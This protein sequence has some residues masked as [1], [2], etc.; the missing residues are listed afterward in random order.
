MPD[1]TQNKTRGVADH[2]S[3]VALQGNKTPSCGE[4]FDLP[5]TIPLHTIAPIFLGPEKSLVRSVKNGF[6]TI[7][8]DSFDNSKRYRNL[9]LSLLKMK[10][11]RRNG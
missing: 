1:Y 3:G 10:G 5:L 4:K 8:S 9:D 7:L 11:Y 2:E 6:G